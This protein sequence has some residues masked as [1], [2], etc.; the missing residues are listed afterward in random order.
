MNDLQQNT[1]KGY[2]IGDLKKAIKSSPHFNTVAAAV[3]NIYT[4][5]IEDDV[6]IK[7]LA[8]KD[9]QK[10]LEQTGWEIDGKLLPEQEKEFVLSNRKVIEQQLFE[11]ST[12]FSKIEQDKKS[13]EQQL[14]ELNKN[15]NEREKSKESTEQQLNK[16]FAL[17]S[18][19]QK[20]LN[21]REQ[22]V[23]EL[24]RAL[25]EREQEVNRLSKVVN[26]SEQGVNNLSL[27][28]NESEQQL[29]D[30]KKRVNDGEQLVSD[31][32]NRLNESEQAKELAEQRLNERE[33]QVNDLVKQLNERE[34]KVNELNE[35]V[36]N[37]TSKLNERAGKVS[38]LE[39]ALNELKAILNK[40]SIFSKFAFDAINLLLGLFMTISCLLI[41]TSDT[42]NWYSVGFGLT[43]SFLFAFLGIGMHTVIKFGRTE[44]K[45]VAMWVLILLS[46][47]EIYI[48]YKS[49]THFVSANVVGNVELFA[50]FVAVIV[51][52]INYVS[53]WFKKD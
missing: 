52:I 44:Q 8:S 24:E 37:L 2:K 20:Q 32:N 6:E 46:I 5:A 45:S 47:S 41:F 25:N 29:N 28:V 9:L 51:A 30:F 40:K 4:L 22:Q 10:F 18:D 12:K 1:T 26:E 21:E 48:H 38:E 50:A 36:N 14:S 49:V 33:Q 13:L 31:L 43:L 15:L 53:F 35:H 23:N 3:N 11:L 16:N 42:A 19:I 27:K 39:K 34:N 17:V 7:V